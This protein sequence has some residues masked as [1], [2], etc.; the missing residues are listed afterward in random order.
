MIYF[1]DPEYDILPL[2]TDES[3][4]DWGPEIMA[5]ELLKEFYL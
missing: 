5:P 4:W 2:F 3:C 1:P